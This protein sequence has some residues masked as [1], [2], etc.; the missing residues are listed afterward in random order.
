MTKFEEY[1]ESKLVDSWPGKDCQGNLREV[2][3]YATYNGKRYQMSFIIVC[4]A[5]NQVVRG[6]DTGEGSL[7]VYHGSL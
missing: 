6:I 5:C 1:I 4:D 7:E 3:V 2:P